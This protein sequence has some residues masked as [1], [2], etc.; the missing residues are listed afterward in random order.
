MP[1]LNQEPI[2]NLMF[3]LFRITARKTQKV[4]FSKVV[5][6][7]SNYSRSVDAK[8]DDLVVQKFV[9]I[10]P[11]FMLKFKNTEL[12]IIIEIISQ[13]K[14]NNALW[15]AR[16]LKRGGTLERAIS[17]LVKGEVIFKTSIPNIY[18]VNPFYIRNGDIRTIIVAT[19]LFITNIRRVERF[20]IKALTAPESTT[21]EPFRAAVSLSPEN[22]KF[23]EKA[24][25]SWF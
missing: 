20:T 10:H 24:M 11:K 19:Y 8:Y 16:N 6:D 21:V 17:T 1:T 4:R 2:K 7:G 18:I 15:H 25:K 14:K 9:V 13:L 12:K 5:F 3:T 22:Q 23:I